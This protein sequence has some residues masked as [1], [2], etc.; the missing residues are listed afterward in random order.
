MSKLQETLRK[1]W[2][3][4]SDEKTQEGA[5]TANNPEALGY[6]KEI[7]YPHKPM[8]VPVGGDSR[9]WEQKW[10]ENAA[11]DTKKVMGPSGEEFKLKQEL[12]RIPMDEKIANA[13]LRAVF[14]R[15]AKPQTSY[16]TV[17]AIDKKSGKKEEILKATIADLWGNNVTEE[18]A[19]MTASK[20]Y[21]QEV[22]AR[23][24]NK[25]N[26]PLWGFANVLADMT[27]NSSLLKKSEV[28]ERTVKTA[29]MYQQELSEVNNSVEE[30]AGQD[31]SRA[32]AT[33]EELVAKKEEV[34]QAE[35]K[36]LELLPETAAPVGQELQAVEQQLEQAIGEQTAIAAAL[37]NKTISASAK[38]KLMKIAEDAFLAATE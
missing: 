5:I 36:L 23:I 26:N 31:A 34:E 8:E 13:N 24:R 28:K 11:K 3:Q 19:K 27:G 21:G 38:V 1:A 30:A 37:R 22:I 14:T 25:G 17:T 15:T 9:D 10:F 2:F 7:A 33:K 29:E 6:P 18:E 20:E 35:T 4:G 32:D 12:Q 16:W